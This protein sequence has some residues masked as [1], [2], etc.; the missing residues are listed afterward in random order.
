MDFDLRIFIAHVVTLE[1]R[2]NATLQ[3]KSFDPTIKRFNGEN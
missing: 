3:S 2:S 1:R